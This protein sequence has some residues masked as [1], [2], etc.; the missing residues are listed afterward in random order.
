MNAERN[1]QAKTK[2]AAFRI[3]QLQRNWTEQPYK[4]SEE[5]SVFAASQIWKVIDQARK[6]EKIIDWSIPS[7]DVAH[8]T[9]AQYQKMVA[10]MKA[11]QFDAFGNR[12]D[13]YSIS[14][15]AITAKACKVW[16]DRGRSAE[17]DVE[18]ILDISK[19]LVQENVKSQIRALEERT[20]DPEDTAENAILKIKALKTM[21]TDQMQPSYDCSIAVVRLLNTLPCARTKEQLEAVFTEIDLIVDVA[22]LT[23]LG[24]DKEPKVEQFP[25]PPPIQLIQCLLRCIPHTNSLGGIR[26]KLELKKLN[27]D[28]AGKT[29][30][31]YTLNDW[32]RLKENILVELR[33]L[34]VPRQDLEEVD[35]TKSF[36]AMML[37][38]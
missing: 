15:F 13:G 9:L 28:K 34:T 24:P 17:V 2:L 27:I 25:V 20:Y 29:D 32:E 31:P 10:Y 23:L 33:S 1:S 6:K 11:D 35:M 22:K 36:S 12:K 38:D 4:G 18:K 7:K 37:P 26:D 19:G 5:E 21:F 16:E 3:S 30:D 8:G 14:E